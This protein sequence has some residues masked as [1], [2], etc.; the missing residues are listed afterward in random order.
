MTNMGEDGTGKTDWFNNIQLNS[1]NYGDKNTSVDEFIRSDFLQ[2]LAHEMLH[3]NQNAGNFLLS[4]QFR[5]G[6]PVGYRHRQLDEKATNIITPQ[7]QGQFR[8]ALNNGD[9]GCSCSR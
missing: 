5:M 3:V 7:L 9:V 8:K 4:N 6:N 2:T 1:R